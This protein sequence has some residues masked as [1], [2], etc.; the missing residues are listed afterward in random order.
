VRPSRGEWP[1]WIA[2][3]AVLVVPIWWGADASFPWD[4][5]NLAP[6]SV[7]KGLSMGF[8]KGW[9]SS[10]GP[11]P[12]YLMGLA[13]MPVLVVMKLVHE[14]GN[15][16]GAWPH[17]FR[18][19]WF[20][21]TVL[22]VTAR[23]TTVACALGI[24]WLAARRARDDDPDGP[25]W[26]VPLL[27]LG[28][29]QFAYYGRTSN[30]DVHS[31]FWLFLGV[32]LAEAPRGSLRRLC[33]GAAAAVCALCCKEQAAPAG[34]VIGLACMVQ[35]WRLPG[36]AA[37]RMRAVV[38]VGAAAVATYVLL[39]QL[40]FNLSGW[41]AHNEFL[42]QEA[43][44]PRK[45]P[46]T[47]AGFAALGARAMSF[48]PLALGL[49]VLAGLV[50][51][52]AQRVSLRGLGVRGWVVLA[53]LAGFV[54]RIGYVYPRFLLPLLLLAL[55]LAVRGLAV[56]P[57][58]RGAVAALVVVLGLA[59]GPLVSWLMLADP[60]LPAER[61][62]RANVPGHATVEV[63]GNAHANVRVP[64]GPVIVRVGAD[65]LAV[66]PRGPVGDVVVVSSADSVYFSERS[67]VRTAWWEPLHASP[68]DGSWRLAAAFP[69]PPG[70]GLVGEMWL[71]PAIEIYARVRPREAR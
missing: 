17:G 31:L 36:A 30:A 22:V 35:A 61:W 71:G 6:G 2:L 10:Y 20:S 58:W 18:H 66:R 55:P 65:E 9:Y 32:R 25:R 45:Y 57:R 49:P 41:R 69:R 14:L 64:R 23:L 48:L 51:A 62:L 19:P 11:L 33:A 3:A 70:A 52:L 42:W 26:L 67:E 43:L 16:T 1:A 7:L 12:Y 46:A 27:L 44:Y 38:L 50:S 8:G 24:A 15:P 53:H 4:L 68:P 37:S 54:A 29:A 5:D 47:P 39:W 34:A 40:P 56:P 21:I 13:Y 63:A 28:S 60:R 59:G